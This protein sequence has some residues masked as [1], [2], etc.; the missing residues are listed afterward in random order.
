MAERLDRNQADWNQRANQ[1]P[2]RSRESGNPG[3]PLAAPEKGNERSRVLAWVPAF[4]GTN[5]KTKI[6]QHQSKTNLGLDR[7]KLVAGSAATVGAVLLG[8]CDRIAGSEDVQNALG[9]AEGATR[10]VQRL[11]T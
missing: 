9:K 1:N 3:L 2:V 7:R 11:L 6:T 4:A 5:G 10:R 8:G